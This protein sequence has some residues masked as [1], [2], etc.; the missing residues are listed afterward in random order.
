MDVSARRRKRMGMQ[1]NRL[2]SICPKLCA[3]KCR[4][5]RLKRPVFG[6]THAV[7]KRSFPL[8]GTRTASYS[9]SSG[10]GLF[11]HTLSCVCRTCVVYEWPLSKSERGR[12]PLL[13]SQTELSVRAANQSRGAPPS[14]GREDQFLSPQS[15]CA[16][17]S[18]APRSM[19]D[20]LI[21]VVGGIVGV[22]VVYFFFN[23]FFLATPCFHVRGRFIFNLILQF[24]FCL[25]DC[26]VKA[27][28]G[29]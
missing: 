29:F 11:V 25:P 2:P 27:E 14:S 20:R 6:I 24:W 23:F 1:R 8:I 17:L 16:E 3:S 28:R 13:Q 10:P 12:L 5:F 18:G 9:L 19:G 21:V 15:G 7:R 4:V 22:V 26:Q